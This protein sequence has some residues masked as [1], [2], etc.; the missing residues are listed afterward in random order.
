M[1]TY[2][3]RANA[4]VM[5]EWA[6][7]PEDQFDFVHERSLGGSIADWKRFMKQ[8][9]DNTKPGGWTEFQEYEGYA[10]SDSDPKLDHSP[11]LRDW[12][13]LINEASSKFGKEFNIAPQLK[14]LMIDTGWTDI[15]Q[16]VVHVSV[17]CRISD[18]SSHAAVAKSSVGT[19]RSMGE[20]QKGKGD[21][22]VPSRRSV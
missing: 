2:A 13:E 19:D 12:V 11:S 3:L 14:Q 1:E 16:K 9:Y 8:C 17:P 15:G 22:P 7:P 21:G 20:R 10:Y 18:L 4:L 5:V 6:Y